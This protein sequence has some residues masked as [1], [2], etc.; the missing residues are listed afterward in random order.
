M[1]NPTKMLFVTALALTIPLSTWAGGGPEMPPYKGSVEL[2]RLKSLAGTWKGKEDMGQGVQ[3]VVATY[4]VT[5]NGSAV[6]ETLFPKTPHEMI[7]VYHD[8]NGKLT[9]THY[10]MLGNQPHMKL[11]DSGPTS[12]ALVMHGKEGITNANEP[13]MH[14]LTIKFVD[15]D[16]IEHLWTHHKDGKASN[17]VTFRLTRSK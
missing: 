1:F 6:I 10:C 15:A 11:K 9:M 16:T 7:S 5:A 8:E 3:D 12:I 17:T 14:A 13:H 2:E 4:A